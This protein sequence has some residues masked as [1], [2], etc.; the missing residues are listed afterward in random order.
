MSTSDITRHGIKAHLSNAV[1][2]G[3]VAY[4]AG[5]TP[6]SGTT[7]GEQ[8]ASVLE[9]IDGWLAAAGTSKA[10]LLSAQIW[11][12]DIRNRDAMNEVWNA[13]VAPGAPPARACVE[14]KLASPEW[15]VE[16]MVTA[17]V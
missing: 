5:V 10:R 17:A 12:T 14:A 3:G 13:W 9:Q 1:V 2:H 11:L 8:T 16:I 15:L 7:V 6:A 4:L